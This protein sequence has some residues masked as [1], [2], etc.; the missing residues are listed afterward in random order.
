VELDDAGDFGK[1]LKSLRT[2][3]SVINIRAAG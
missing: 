1:A 3:P 2:I